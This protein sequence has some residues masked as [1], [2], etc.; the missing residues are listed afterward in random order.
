MLFGLQ[1]TSYKMF[2]DIVKKIEDFRID[3]IKFQG[4]YKQ[5]KVNIQEEKILKLF[6]EEIN[7]GR[8]KTREPMKSQ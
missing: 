5:L 8:I 7:S 1:M 6:D 2:D 4:K 3:K